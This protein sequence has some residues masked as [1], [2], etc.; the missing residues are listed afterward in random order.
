M[1]TNQPTHLDYAEEAES[2]QRASAWPQAAALWQRAIDCAEGLDERHEYQRSMEA[3]QRNMA[4]DDELE[5]IARRV[6]DIETLATRKSDSLDF[7]EVCVWGLKDALRQAY[8]T[9]RK[10]AAE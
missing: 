10:S 3:C 8:H 2:A 4:I 1:K 7:H 6:L 9:G 5:S